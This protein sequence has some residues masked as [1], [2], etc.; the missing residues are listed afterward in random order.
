[1]VNAQRS[2]FDEVQREPGIHAQCDNQQRLHSVHNKYEV[3]GLLVGNGALGLGL[4]LGSACSGT[5]GDGCEGSI[6]QLFILA[7]DIGKFLTVMHEDET[8]IVEGGFA[9]AELPVHLMDADECP[10]Q[11]TVRDELC[12]EAAGE[13]DAERT[14][15]RFFKLLGRFVIGGELGRFQ[16]PFR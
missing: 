4:L 9:A 11:I 8:V 3:K 5:L 10:V 2:M 7:D 1:M 14:D 15:T 12:A 16:L 13:E 6:G